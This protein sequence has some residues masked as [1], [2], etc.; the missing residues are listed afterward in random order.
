MR[1]PPPPRFRARFRTR[2][3]ARSASPIAIRRK[4]SSSRAR[5]RRRSL[6]PTSRIIPA[7]LSA[8]RTVGTV[9]RLT[10]RFFSSHP[11][12]RSYIAD[13]V[14]AIVRT[15]KTN[16]LRNAAPPP[17]GNRV[18]YLRRPPPGLTDRNN[19]NHIED[20]KINKK[21]K[22]VIFADDVSLV[23]YIVDHEQDE[24]RL[25]SSERIPLRAAASGRR[26][27]PRRIRAPPPLS[28]GSVEDGDQGRN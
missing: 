4:S 21:N 8:R 9:R 7:P 17:R 28:L 5:T 16:T 12:T 19:I 3:R 23:R 22:G 20:M 18:P 1:P 27:I 6:S 2:T 25:V 13:S 14:P 10:R 24:D 15:T 11:F 26:R